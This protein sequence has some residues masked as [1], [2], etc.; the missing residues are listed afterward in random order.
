MI[1]LESSVSE[2]YGSGTGTAN[3]IDNISLFRIAGPTGVKD[4]ALQGNVAVYPNPS[5]GT[6]KVNLPGNK[7][8]ALEV[9]DLT[10]KVIQ[11]LETV[12]KTELKLENKAKGLYLL[13][14]TSDG[15][16]TVRKL[17]VE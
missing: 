7:V 1:G 8:Y 6:F 15:A 13:K 10:G 5:N 11:Q 2:A 17:I 14:V 16:T 12:G 4:N 9:T 3:L